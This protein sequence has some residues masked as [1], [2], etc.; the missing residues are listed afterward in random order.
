MEDRR[1]FRSRWIGPACLALALTG[2]VR[3]QDTSP[4]E[5]AKGG[6]DERIITVRE[7][8]HPPE[9]CRVLKT[10]TERDGSRATQVQALDGGEIMT[11]VEQKI[12]GGTPGQGDL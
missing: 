2:A 6:T 3:G 5:P 7:L 12:S 4:A 10:W 1:M 8:D 11:I 9:R